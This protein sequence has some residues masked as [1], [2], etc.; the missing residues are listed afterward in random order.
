MAGAEWPIGAQASPNSDCPR[1]TPNGAL[2]PLANVHTLLQA[3]RKP[4][5]FPSEWFDALVATP[6][7]WDD[8]KL[9]YPLAKARAAPSS[10]FIVPQG[11]S[12]RQ[13]RIAGFIK[14]DGSARFARDE[15][16]DIGPYGC[17][18][19]G[20][21]FYGSVPHPPRFKQLIVSPSEQH[22]LSVN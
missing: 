8:S 9:F 10:F 17:V 14:S 3:P 2:L 21:W 13:Q 19:L 1:P 7:L 16:C 11:E 4:Q 5:F 18:N 22:G 15:M 12:A 20:T 6:W